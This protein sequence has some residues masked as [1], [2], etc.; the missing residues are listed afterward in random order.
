MLRAFPD[1]PGSR[2]PRF[3]RCTRSAHAAHESRAARARPIAVAS[4]PASAADRAAASSFEGP[5]DDL[6]LLKDSRTRR[7]SSFNPEGANRDYVTVGPGETLT[8]AS[9]EGAGIIRRVYIVQLGADRMRY[10]K[11]MLR[12][13]WD[14]S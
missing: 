9:I 13:Y 6:F 5:F 4:R 10:R 1:S 14:G 12:M 2:P 7:I 11:L 3:E 8:L